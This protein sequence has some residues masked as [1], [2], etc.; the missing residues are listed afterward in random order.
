M[1]QRTPFCSLLLGAFW[2]CCTCLLTTA[3]PGDTTSNLVGLTMLGVVARVR[4]QIALDAQLLSI[5]F[6]FGY[7]WHFCYLFGAFTLGLW[8]LLA[9]STIQ[10]FDQM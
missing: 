7:F 4:L 9:P 8:V 2:S 3:N 6:A 5:V 1:K 10:R